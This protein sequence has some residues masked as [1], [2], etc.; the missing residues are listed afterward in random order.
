MPSRDVNAL[1]PEVAAKVRAW[2]A[3]CAA[4]GVEVLVYCTYRS[5]DEQAELYARG[6]TKPGRRVTNAPAWSSW[7]NHRRAADA[8]PLRSGKPLWRY[9][10][11]DVE[12]QVYAEE[13]KRAG[14]EWAGTWKK[15][16]EFDHVQDTGGLTLAQA[17]AQTRGGEQPEA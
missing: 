9:D 16:R 1:V 5:A 17:Y 8:V 6:R 15:F 12:W 13:A 10:A 14:L 3:A 2:V 7:H 11:D 4:R